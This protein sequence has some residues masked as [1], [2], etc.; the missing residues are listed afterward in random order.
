VVLVALQH[1]LPSGLAQMGVI[2]TA[3]RDDTEFLFDIG[4]DNIIDYRTRRFEGIVQN[5]DIVFDTVG[6][7]N[8]ERSWKVLKKRKGKLVSISVVEMPSSE[9]SLPLYIQ[10]K[11]S[12]HGVHATWFIVKPNRSQ[13]TRIRDLIDAGDVRP[14]C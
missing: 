8:L 7:D 10:K 3:S 11:W 1:N 12:S 13:L 4:A 2:G 9:H 6:G 5:I 14:D